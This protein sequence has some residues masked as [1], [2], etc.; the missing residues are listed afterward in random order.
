MTKFVVFV[1]LISGPTVIAESNDWA[2]ANNT[3]NWLSSG[4]ETPKSDPLQPADTTDLNATGDSAMVAQDTSRVDSIILDPILYQPGEDTILIDV[5]RS[6]GSTEGGERSPTITLFQSVAFPGWG[7]FSNRK[8]IKAGLV[9]L[10]ET[11]FIYK[12][13]DYGQL[14]SE[15]RRKWK[16][17]PPELKNSYFAE[18]TGHRD[19]RN[20][21]L[22]YT[23]LTIF[24]SMFD[25]YVDAHLRNFPDDVPDS[26]KLLLDITPGEETRLSLRYNF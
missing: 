12:A 21:N 22:W 9:F 5:Y 7:Q 25:A 15:W 26:D 4:S 1:L 3:P 8:Y 24:F 6:R 10:V 19:R 14:A 16:E 2:G 20:T 17:A 23:A 13:V 18:Y 11:Y